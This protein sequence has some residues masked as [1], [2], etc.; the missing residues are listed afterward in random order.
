VSEE[1]QRELE[2]DL[3]YHLRQFLLLI[4]SS[5]MLPGSDEQR[6]VVRII[7]LFSLNGTLTNY[8]LRFIVFIHMST[9]A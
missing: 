1:M 4:S 5:E 7:H 3:T 6:L 2:D 8:Y 9:I